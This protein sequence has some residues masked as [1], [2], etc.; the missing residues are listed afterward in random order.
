MTNPE[1]AQNLLFLFHVFFLYFQGDDNQRAEGGTL[2]GWAEM[3]NG[4]DFKDIYYIL[5]I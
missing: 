3:T 5:C 4:G 2:G 1:K